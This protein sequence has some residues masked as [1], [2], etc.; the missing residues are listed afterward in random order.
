MKLFYA[1]P[2]AVVKLNGGKSDIHL[3][4]QGICHAHVTNINGFSW[5]VLYRLEFTFLCHKPKLENERKMDKRRFQRVTKIIQ[6]LTDSQFEATPSHG[7]RWAV[8][9]QSVFLPSP[10]TNLD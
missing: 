9:R 10:L 6:V 1:Y 7:L 3:L 5:Q 2:L 4:R 8:A